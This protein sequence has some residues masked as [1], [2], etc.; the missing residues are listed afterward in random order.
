MR[1]AASVVVACALLGACATTTTLDVGKALDVAWS[2]LKVAADS[3]DVLVKL[4]KLHGAQAATVSADLKTATAALQAATDAYHGLNKT[5]DPNMQIVIATTA[6]TEIG[7][8]I[9]S[10]K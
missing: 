3:S 4:G 1:R 9:G 8:I 2:G 10:L 6:V 7:A 5:A